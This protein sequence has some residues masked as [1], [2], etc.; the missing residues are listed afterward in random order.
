MD[1][2]QMVLASGEP[3]RLLSL[4]GDKATVESP[5]AFPPGATLTCIVSNEGNRLGDFQVKV[6]RCRRVGEVFHVDGR[7]RNAVR[8]VR[9]ALPSLVAG[10]EG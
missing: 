5:I 10:A 4:D 9:A 3:A 8:E 6:N 1:R 7:L 2:A